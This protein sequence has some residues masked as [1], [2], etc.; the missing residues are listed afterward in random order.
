MQTAFEHRES[1]KHK[2]AK[3]VFKQWA[4]GRSLFP[5]N[6]D[7]DI[8]WSS[9][10]TEDAWL[11][12]PIVITENINSVSQNWDEIWSHDGMYCDAEL[13]FVPSYE[14]CIGKNLHP[15]AV[16]DIIL[17]H[18][19]APGYFIEICHTNPVSDDKIKKLH[20]AGVR[21]LIEFDAEWIL[22]QTGIP[23]KLKIKRWLI[24]DGI[25]QAGTL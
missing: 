22:C 15:I 7:E 23:A 6:Y 2:Y 16:I 11:E 25:I 4:S 12:Y 21:E 3:E 13:N 19:G 10:R 24:R 5:T 9:N 14:E 8:D 17:P 20:A 1:Y 18:K